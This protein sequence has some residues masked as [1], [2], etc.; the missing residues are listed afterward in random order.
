MQLQ[1][2]PQRG[3]S[4]LKSPLTASSAK[5]GMFKSREFLVM[6]T[7]WFLVKAEDEALVA[8][9]QNLRSLM[10]RCG[11]QNIKN[12]VKL[13]YEE[14]P[15]LGHLISKDGLKADPAKIITVLEI[16][17]LT[18]VARVRRF[19]GFTNY[20]GKFL[21]RLSNVCEP[22]RKLT[23]P[24]IGCFWTNHHNSAVQRVKQLVTYA[25]YFDSTKG[26]TLQC[27]A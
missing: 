4:V 11:E 2:I 23:T 5:S 20:L 3:R 8:N 15:F 18:D 9:D 24:D 19:I 6:P 13:R 26:L 25:P 17:T 14:L 7:S 12:K 22:F 16:P 21:L 27:D 1:L 10:Q